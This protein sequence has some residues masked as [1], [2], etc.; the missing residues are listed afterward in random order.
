M[1][2]FSFCGSC[3]DTSGGAN[4]L[5]L[6]TQYAPQKGEAT[7]FKNGK[8][9]DEGVRDISKSELCSREKIM[10]FNPRVVPQSRTNQE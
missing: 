10:N 2:F 1:L 4:T 8:I 7:S 9:N 3:V 5:L 6:H